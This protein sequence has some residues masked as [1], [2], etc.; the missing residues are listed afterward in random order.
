MERKRGWV[1]GKIK[2]LWEKTGRK[3]KRGYG[4]SGEVRGGGG[5][6]SK[7]GG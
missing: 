2:L 3:W 6:G 4:E 5:G 7:G 1:R